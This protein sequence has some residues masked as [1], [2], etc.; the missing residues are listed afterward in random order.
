MNKTTGLI[1][2][3]II[4][5]LGVGGLLYLYFQK[6]IV[7]IA[8]IPPINTPNFQLHNI[9]AQPNINQPA[10]NL[11]INRNPGQN[12]VINTNINQPD[13]QPASISIANFAFNPTLLS[14]KMGTT[15]TW[16]ND[17]PAPH[18]IVGSVFNSKALNTGDNFSYTFT[19]T[20]TYDYHCAIHPSMIGQI[21]VQ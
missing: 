2:I 13:Y 20:G 12:N 4:V 6:S 8:S 21:I 19:Q 17:D 16:I 5:I 18:Q 1:I 3:T 15:V 9:N 10:P 11:N 14:V 7:P